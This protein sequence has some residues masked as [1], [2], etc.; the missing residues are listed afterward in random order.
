MAGN[1][2]VKN[3]TVVDGRGAAPAG[4][5]DVVIRDGRFQ[6]PRRAADSQRDAAGARVIEGQGK[7]LVPGLWESHTHLRPVLKDGEQASQAALDATL[8]DYLARGIT[9]VVDLG[10]PIAPYSTLRDRQRASGPAGRAQLLFAGPSFTG[11]NG[12]PMSLHHNPTCAYE[13]GDAPTAVHRLRELLERQ[14]DVI[15]V[16]YDGEPGSPEKLPL[17]A[18]QAIVARSHEHGVRVVVHVRTAEDSFEALDA[19]AD[20]LE[21]SFL[22]TPGR[23]EAEAEQLTE[24]L[25][26][27]GAYLTPT[28]PFGS[29]W[30]G[31]GRQLSGR[32]GSGRLH[33][34]GR[35]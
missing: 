23:E 11:I 12:W 24:V 18:L 8:S 27:T 17:P 15:K 4:G 22:P 14:P 3:V 35:G 6:A 25:R 5:M 9:S 10:G 20:G 28:W 26:R 16:I 32:A 13:I 33:D 30:P 21:H 7:F 19:G 31:R 29:S 34:P 2:I 1:V